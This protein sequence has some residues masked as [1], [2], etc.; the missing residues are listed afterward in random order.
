[1]K[2][3]VEEMGSP[4]TTTGGQATL[5]GFLKIFKIDICKFN[6]VLKQKS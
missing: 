1:M 5:A 2:K 4:E 6:F 3:K